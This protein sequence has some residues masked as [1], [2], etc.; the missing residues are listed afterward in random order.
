MV[1]SLKTPRDLFTL[2]LLFH[3]F[4]NLA[5]HQLCHFRMY[6]L[7]QVGIIVI[8]F[9]TFSSFKSNKNVKISEI[10]RKF[11]IDYTIGYLKRIFTN[12]QSNFYVKVCEIRI[13]IN[14][15]TLV[16]QDSFSFYIL[17]L[18]MYI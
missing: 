12:N 4:W 9:Q 17:N 14:I 8:C 3:S 13:F 15:S 10:V 2:H 18:C 7:R 1:T 11:E 16:R 5:L 6:L